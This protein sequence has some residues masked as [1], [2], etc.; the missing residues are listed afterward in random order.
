MFSI[1]R[2]NSILNI[3]NTG[4]DG[5]TVLRYIESYQVLFEQSGPKQVTTLMYCLG[6]EAVDIF[7]ASTLTEAEKK[8]YSKV[9]KMFSEVF[10]GKRNVIYE[11]AMFHWR[12]QKEGESFE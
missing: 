7:L 10:I 6:E 4:R 5:L 12:H 3:P 2:H 11:R 9:T 8:N 1:R